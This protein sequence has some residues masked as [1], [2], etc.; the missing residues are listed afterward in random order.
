DT[1][2]LQRQAVLFAVQ[3]CPGSEPRGRAHG[4]ADGAGRSSLVL[5]VELPKQVGAGK[6]VWNDGYASQM[7][8]LASR[9]EAARGNAHATADVGEI[10]QAAVATNTGTALV[11]SRR[12]I[13]SLKRRHHTALGQIAKNRTRCQQGSRRYCMLQATS[14]MAQGE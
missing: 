2:Y 7:A 13:R 12:S 11:I 4:L 3:V 8:I 10:H 1:R 14:R 9:A 6:L 5:P